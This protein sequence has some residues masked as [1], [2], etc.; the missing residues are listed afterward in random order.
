MQ[1]KF[2][3][4]Q[5]TEASRNMP[6]K[7]SLKLKE[8][9]INLDVKFGHTTNYNLF[10]EYVKSLDCEIVK[11]KYLQIRNTFVTNFPDGTSM[12]FPH[13]SDDFT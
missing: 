10:F 1:E 12:S 5:S 3:N 7:K 13:K 4:C 2:N 9:Q 11:S 6:P 8:L